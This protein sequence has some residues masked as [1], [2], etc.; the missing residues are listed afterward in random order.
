MSRAEER[1]WVWSM[2]ELAYHGNLEVLFCRLQGSRDF[3]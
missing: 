2:L 3:Q 1:K